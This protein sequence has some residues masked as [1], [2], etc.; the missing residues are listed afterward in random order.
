M[1]SGLVKAEEE[2]IRFRIVNV[3]VH[4]NGNKPLTIYELECQ[5]GQKKWTIEK[6]FTDFCEFHENLQISLPGVEL[7]SAKAIFDPK[8]LSKKSLSI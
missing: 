6:K 3:A 5:K 7:S 4:E 2:M 1:V 8:H